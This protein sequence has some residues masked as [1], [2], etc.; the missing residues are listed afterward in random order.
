VHDKSFD[1]MRKSHTALPMTVQPARPWLVQ[2]IGEAAG[3]RPSQK[4]NPV[5][6]DLLRKRSLKKQRSLMP[7]AA[8]KRDIAKG[9]RAH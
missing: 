5:T 2:P 8:H 4:M 3:K 9:L 1:A 6:A 7:P